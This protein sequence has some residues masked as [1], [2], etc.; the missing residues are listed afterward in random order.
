MS[1]SVLFGIFCYK[2]ITP[3]K[4]WRIFIVFKSFSLLFFMTVHLC[5][6]SF[7]LS[8][9]KQFHIRQYLLK[10]PHCSFIAPFYCVTLGPTNAFLIFLLLAWRRLSLT[11]LHPNLKFFF[12]LIQW[13]FL[14][15]ATKFLFCALSFFHFVVI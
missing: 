7:H 2:N 9:F 5:K 12:Q 6:T 15:I 10:F 13:I 3:I 4:N 11:N 1:Y 8:Y 14:N